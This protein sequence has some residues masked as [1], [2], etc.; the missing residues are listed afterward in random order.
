MATKTLSRKQV[1]ETSAAASIKAYVILNPKGH[2]IGKVQA[3][4]LDSGTVMVD[5]WSTSELIHQGKAG[6]GGYDKFT[7]ALSGA[8]IDGV[9]IFNHSCGDEASNEILSK[10]SKTTSAAKM[11]ELEFEAV[12]IGARFANYGFTNGRNPMSLYYE[13]GLE[14]LTA[15]GYKVIQAI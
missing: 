5:V 10:V 8:V 12:R 4:F 11:K 13:S 2:Y 14:R 1:R 6:G 3:A 15:L 9:K 7:A